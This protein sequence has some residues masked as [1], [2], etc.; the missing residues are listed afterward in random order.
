MLLFAVKNGHLSRKPAGKERWK[1]GKEGRW[2]P[3]KG[4]WKQGKEGCW[5]KGCWK[6]QGLA[7]QKV[8]LGQCRVA[9]G[10]M[11]EFASAVPLFLLLSLIPGLYH[12]PSSL[13]SSKGCLWHWW[14]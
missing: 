2:K 13:R 11:E 12:P 14:R 8:R 3:G 6:Q 7:A 5:K 9:E 4:C 1:L 10:E